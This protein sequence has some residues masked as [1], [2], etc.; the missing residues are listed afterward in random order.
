MKS[1]LK[2]KNAWIADGS[3][4]PLFKGEIL[5]SGGVISGFGKDAGGAAAD[6]TIDLNGKVLAPGFIDAHGHSDVALFANPGAFAKVSQGV[7][8]E[9]A[10]NCGLCA[11]LLGDR[12]RAHLEELY[13][14]YRVDLNWSD[15]PSFQRRLAARS[16]AHTLPAL[17]GH[18]T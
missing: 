11:F 16:V 4:A 8:T 3:G 15:Y 13:A 6:R 7:T 2:I 17:C 5:I 14:D 12:N 18:N 1:S 10:G 9:I